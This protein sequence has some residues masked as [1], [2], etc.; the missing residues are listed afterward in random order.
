ME[1]I[2]DT[3]DD[4]M[5]ENMDNSTKS[6]GNIDERI[7]YLFYQNL[8]FYLESSHSKRI[9]SGDS[10]RYPITDNNHHRRTS[11]EKRPSTSKKPTI[12]E[13]IHTVPDA[14][15]DLTKKKTPSPGKI[16]KQIIYLFYHKFNLFFYRKS[17]YETN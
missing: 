5:K 9:K 15:D 12:A 13:D 14:T 17:A 11:N 2:P 6:P 7:I 1:L 3:T 16:N 10:N 4:P 8:F